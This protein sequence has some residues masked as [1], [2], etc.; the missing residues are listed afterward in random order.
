M[1]AEH[2]AFQNDEIVWPNIQGCEK[3]VYSL[4]PFRINLS[5]KSD[6]TFVFR[7]HCDLYTGKGEGRQ[8]E[9]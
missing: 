5:T 6:T 3:R 4:V 9:K 8:K 1:G 7:T 2:R